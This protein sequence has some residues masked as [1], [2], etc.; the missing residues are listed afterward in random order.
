MKLG[1]GVWHSVLEVKIAGNGEWGA[2]WVSGGGKM[3]VLGVF[4]KG[5]RAGAVVS[6][7]PGQSMPKGVQ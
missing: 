1:M 6:D 7:N 5:G 4:L 3:L 2:G